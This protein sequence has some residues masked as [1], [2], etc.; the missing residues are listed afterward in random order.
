MARQPQALAAPHAVLISAWDAIVREVAL[1]LAP[2]IADKL[3]DF[4]LQADTPVPVRSHAWMLRELVRN[5]LHNAIR[6]APIG[7]A[8]QVVLHPDPSHQHATLQITDQGTGLSDHLMQRLY[9]PFSAGDSRSG[10][11]LGL[12]ICLEIV[13]ALGGR[14]ELRNR[15]DGGSAQG[16]LASS[17]LPL[18]RTT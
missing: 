3:L 15:A 6:H 2:L 10:S 16:L 4:E 13:Q 12:A 9:Q 11:G 1:D 5:L 8:L 17:T 18:A 7:S 14:L